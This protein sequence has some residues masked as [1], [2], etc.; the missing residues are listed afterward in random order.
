MYEIALYHVGQTTSLLF[1][2]VGDPA[3]RA[4]VTVEM[5]INSPEWIDMR[6]RHS[7]EEN[8]FLDKRE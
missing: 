7:R 2:R 6:G 5:V 4:K 8:E 3:K 1:D